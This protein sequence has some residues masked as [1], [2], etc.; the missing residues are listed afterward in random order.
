MGF[1]GVDMGFGFAI[2]VVVVVV[3]V[4]NFS[5]R[6]LPSACAPVAEISGPS[7]TQV[8]LEMTNR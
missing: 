7:N 4:A 1:S 8:D 2:L 5:A 3:M 6:L